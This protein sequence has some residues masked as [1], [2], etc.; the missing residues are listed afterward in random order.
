MVKKLSRRQQQLAKAKRHTGPTL[1]PLTVLSVICLALALLVHW[2]NEHGQD[3]IVGYSH[4]GVP[5]Y[6]S[7]LEKENE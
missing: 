1:G 5:I 3:E 4:H 2:V 7:E 6:Q